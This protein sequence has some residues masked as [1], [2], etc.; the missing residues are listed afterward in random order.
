MYYITY[1]TTAIHLTFGDIGVLKE[2]TGKAQEIFPC[3]RTSLIC[4]RASLLSSFPTHPSVQHQILNSSNLENI[5]RDLEDLMF[6]I[7]V[8]AVSSFNDDQSTDMFGEDRMALLSPDMISDWGSPGP[9]YYWFSKVFRSCN[10]P[11]FRIVLG[12]NIVLTKRHLIHSVL[13]TPL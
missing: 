9:S 13:L 11:S 3:R 7:Y 1:F 4:R 5:P 12:E 2:S 6:S 8:F 10:P